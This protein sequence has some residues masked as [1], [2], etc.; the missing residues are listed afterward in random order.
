MDIYYRG[1][2]QGKIF[3]N[4]SINMVLLELLKN[5]IT[6]P[7]HWG[8][9]KIK[10]YEN[11]HLSDEWYSYM[12]FFDI[13]NDFLTLRDDNYQTFAM[14][15][16]NRGTDYL[17]FEFSKMSCF[18]N[19]ETIIKK[20]L[21]I[22]FLINKEYNFLQSTDNPQTYDSYKVKYDKSKLYFNENI[23]MELLDISQNVGRE[24]DLGI[25]DFYPA[26][27]IWFGREAQDLFG[28][29]KIL[30]FTEAFYVKELPN[31]IIE[32][33]LMD[34]IMKPHLLYNQEKQRKLIEYLEIDKL[35]IKRY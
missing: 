6:F 34:D 16:N 28:K 25:F 11:K 24:R 2:Y 8:G 29:E 26:Y 9:E 1:F 21:M 17:S 31:G 5:K 14:G 27:K 10:I 19:N 15:R 3:N 18:P 7:I 12:N 20:G 22:A 23:Q 33:Q 13:N 35:E 30:N 32:M 4:E